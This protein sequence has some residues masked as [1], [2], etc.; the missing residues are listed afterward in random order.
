[1]NG[2]KIVNIT[3]RNFIYI[4]YLHSIII[5]SSE[6]KNLFQKIYIIFFI[7]LTIKHV[8]GSLLLHARLVILR[9]SLEKLKIA[10]QYGADAVY[11]GGEAF[12]LRAAA[13]NFSFEEIKEGAELAHSL[14]KKIY[15]TVNVMPRNEGIE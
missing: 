1:M 11:F 6:N 12:S 2:K 15:C 9:W 7:F 3:Y 5:S 4:I 13:Q 14:G 8:L 10:F